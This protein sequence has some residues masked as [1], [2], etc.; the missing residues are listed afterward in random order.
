VGVLI[1]NG[2]MLLLLVANILVYIVIKVTVFAKC[3]SFRALHVNKRIFFINKNN[4]CFQCLINGHIAS[5][6]NALNAL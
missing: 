3:E 4:L 2:L 1:Q 6:C 5:Q